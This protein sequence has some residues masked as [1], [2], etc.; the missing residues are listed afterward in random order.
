M[1][2]KLTRE[3]FITRATSLHGK[4]Y[5][6]NRVKYQNTSS[7]VEI[8]CPTH[9]SFWQRPQ[10]HIGPQ[11]QGCRKCGVAKRG[12][13]KTKKH[14]ASFIAD[15]MR[16]HGDRYDY[17]RVVYRSS[18]VKVEIRCRAHGPFFQIPNSHLLGHGCPDC[19]V[20]ERAAKRALTTEEFIEKARAVHGGRYGYEESDYG[21]CDRALTIRCPEHGTFLKTQYSHLLGSGCPECGRRQAAAARTMTKDA[22][23]A[24]AKQVHGERYDY[25]QVSY[26]DSKT[27]VMI[28]CRTHGV[29][30]QIPNSHLQEQ[31]CRK[32]GIESRVALS[33]KSLEDFIGQARAI[34]GDTYDYSKV[35]YQ[36][37]KTKVELICRK[38]DSF[39]QAPNNHIFRKAGC[40]YCAG[41]KVCEDN[42]L[43]TVNPDVAAQ[44]HP[45]RNGALKP[46]DVTG[47]AHDVV[48]WRCSAG[49]EWEA[50][51]NSR[52]KQSPLSR[53]ASRYTGC[54]ICRLQKVANALSDTHPILNG[55]WH[56]TKNGYYTPDYVTAHTHTSYWW[57]CACSEEFQMAVS[58]RAILGLGCPRCNPEQVIATLTVSSLYPEVVPFWHRE[59]DRAPNEVHPGDHTTE[60]RWV[61]EACGSEYL[62][63]AGSRVRAT[64]G[65]PYCTG[66]EVNHTN[67]L[68]ALRPDVAAEWDEKANGGL[69]PDDVTP[70][71][72]RQVWWRCKRNQTHKWR[73]SAHNR[74]GNDSGCPTCNESKGEI[75]IR[76]YLRDKKLRYKSQHRVRG[77]GRFD[78]ATKTDGFA[79]IEYH[80]EQHYRPCA[81]GS[82]KPNA[83]VK[84][85]FDNVRRDRKKEQWCRENKIPMLV[86]PY[87]DYERVSEILDTFFGAREPVISD[88][89]ENVWKYESMRD[90]MLQRVEQA[91]P[92]NLLRQ[93]R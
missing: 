38:H 15:A 11:R 45:T 1:P 87:W 10:N 7:L 55:E 17:C 37:S 86:I 26:R 83:G 77:V 16:V 2:A 3:V 42:C 88:P 78:F 71:S 74:V 53:E 47:S 75:A 5:D 41:K 4:K 31:G 40:P 24:R 6:Y 66:R 64:K 23:V 69:T 56:K 32:C 59:N 67:S 13:L 8:V 92:K 81:F 50:T 60:Y 44:W 46:T 33:R 48:W 27:P 90:G 93:A 51:V 80:G 63:T 34:H 73:A 49:H 29:F 52:R 58:L 85:L 89:P 39:F 54:P 43:L 68:A 22:F 72:H 30:G 12:R 19:G 76:R 28:V 25:S 70:G 79:V 65:C 35:A 62:A 20:E 91:E 18:Q 84:N 82:S 61:C 21:N 9:G 57:R 14:A 36:D